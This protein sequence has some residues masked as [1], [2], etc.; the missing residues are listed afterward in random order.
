M[1][2]SMWNI[3]YAL[4]SK[5]KVPMIKVGDATIV[6]ARWIATSY[7]NPDRVYVGNESEFFGGEERNTLIVHRHDMIL[8][9]DTDPE[10]VFEEI[11]CIIEDY[12]HWE[13]ELKSCMKRED[14]LTHMINCS[15]KFLNNPSYIYAPDGRALAKA[16]VEDFPLD[17]YWHWREIHENNGLTDMRMEYLKKEISLSRVFQDMYPV[18]RTASTK[19]YEFAHISLVV[20]GYMAGHYVVFGWQN[21]FNEGSV[22]II[23]NL[24][25]HLTAYITEHYAE[26]SPTTPIG[27]LVTSLIFHVGV[28]EVELQ[29]MLDTLGWQRNDEFRFFVVKEKVDKELVLLP[30]MYVAL[31]KKLSHSVVFMLDDRLVILVNE[32]KKS[33]WSTEQNYISTA[34]S[35]EFLC[36]IS[37]YFSDL[38]QCDKYYMQA[39]KELEYCIANN[40]LISYAEEH[41]IE[42][43]QKAI[44]RDKLG[45]TYVQKDIVC[46]M[47]YDKQNNTPFYHTL[48]TWFYCGFHMATTAKKLGIHRN[49]LTYRLDKIRELI[50][51][52]EID[53]LVS[54]RNTE[55][56]NYFFYSF[57]YLDSK[58]HS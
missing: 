35:R 4:S 16:S 54:T 2:L 1:K 53:Q 23:N 9:R 32:S 27:D 31:S 30:K 17:I 56:L 57:F 55:K 38:E 43:F 13:E 12:S 14:G 15:K 25:R 58:E 21:A 8:V 42:Y 26:F 11:C 22:H 10:E 41:G 37:N 7:F 18:I 29:H 28:D 3:Y 6:S 36:G 44:R 20:G 52:T 48:K 45:E 5:D 33:G 40:R 46:L 39:E 49:S 47:Q 24:A 51:F 34:L 19:D 50:D